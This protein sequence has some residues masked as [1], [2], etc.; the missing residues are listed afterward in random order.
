MLAPVGIAVDGAGG[1]YVADLY[2]D[3]V[4]KFRLS[5]LLQSTPG[6]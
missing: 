2:R 5:P 1:V 6:T 3:R 4:M